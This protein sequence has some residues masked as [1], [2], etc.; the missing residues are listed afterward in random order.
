MFSQ[1]HVKCRFPVQLKGV[2]DTA[3]AGDRLLRSSGRQRRIVLTMATALITGGTSGIGAAFARTLADRGNDI[4][5]VARSRDR[6]EAMATEL[7]MAGRT[8]E[9]IQADLGSRDDVAR[10]LARL[11][12]DSR[13]IEILINNAGFG[14]S[15]DLTDQ[16]STLHDQALEVMCRS[17]LVLSAAAARSMR[18]RGAGTIVN[19]SSTAGFLAMGSYSAIKA[20]V[21]TFTESLAVELKG[22]GVRVTALCP[23]WVRTELHERAGIPSSSIPN[24]MWLNS[25]DL[26]EACLRDV[27]KGK[28]ISIPTLRYR[29]IIWMIRHS[30]RSA[31]RAL[32]GAISEQ[33]RRHPVAP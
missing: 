18:R 24:G 6:L 12:D 14:I 20:W 1:V 31:V 4:V 7:G 19:V 28:V 11:A 29:L 15:T 32:S 5:L 25:E 3:D 16:D 13:P 22:T 8:V 23:G 21:T 17:V 26:V 27:D 30:P 2:T 9:I 10:V 33:R